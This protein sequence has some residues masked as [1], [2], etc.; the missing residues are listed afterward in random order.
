MKSAI[1]AAAGVSSLVVIC[2]GAWLG[3]P[4][5]FV[6]PR[7]LADSESAQSAGGAHRDAGPCKANDEARACDCC[8]TTANAIRCTVG[9]GLPDAGVLTMPLC[10]GGK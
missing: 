2:V 4:T 6:P 1:V 10:R 7:P 3:Y 9:I 5:Q 8:F